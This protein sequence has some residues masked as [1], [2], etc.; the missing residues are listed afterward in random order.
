MNTNDVCSMCGVE[1]PHTKND[2]VSAIPT[3]VDGAGHLCA[4]CWLKV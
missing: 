1:V 4:T 2:N 3:Y